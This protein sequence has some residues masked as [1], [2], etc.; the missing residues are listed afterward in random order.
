MFMSSNFASVYLSYVR[1]NDDTRRERTDQQR[2]KK[3]EERTKSKE[4]EGSKRGTNRW[5]T[6]LKD[7]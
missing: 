4:E 1:K 6:R 3:I 2:G 7:K 5:E